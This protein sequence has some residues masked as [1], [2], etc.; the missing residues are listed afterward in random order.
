MVVQASKLGP[1]R[2]E[3]S[4]EISR[5]SLGELSLTPHDMSINMCRQSVD[6]HEYTAG[7][8]MSKTGY[9]FPKKSSRTKEIV[10]VAAEVLNT[11]FMRKRK[12]S[13]TLT[14]VQPSP[15]QV[16]QNSGPFAPGG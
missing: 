4:I 10:L 9:S 1:K 6:V 5:K 16:T 7:R 8:E 15:S 14:T 13:N 2:M 3:S 12:S 11:D